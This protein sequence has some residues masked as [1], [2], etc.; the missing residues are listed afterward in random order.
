MLRTEAYFLMLWMGGLIR[1]IIR[2]HQEIEEEN[3]RVEEREFSN[4]EGGARRRTRAHYH[5][6]INYHS[7]NRL[8]LRY[9]ESELNGRT[10]LFKTTEDK[11][12]NRTLFESQP[13]G[14][15]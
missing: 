10:K 1:R 9:A 12:G 2:E 7:Q 14:T 6:L 8:K 4:T 11:V 13:C 15:K 5:R 3:G